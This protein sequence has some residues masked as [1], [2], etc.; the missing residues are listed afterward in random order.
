MRRASTELRGLVQTIRASSGALA[1]SRR[2]LIEPLEA[3]LEHKRKALIVAD[4]LPEF[5]SK[6]RK[7][8]GR[9]LEIERRVA[10]DVEAFVAP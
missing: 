5:C 9:A 10:A 8:L 1:D 2:Q 7:E 6:Y 4:A 3:A